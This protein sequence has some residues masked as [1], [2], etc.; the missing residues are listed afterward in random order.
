[1]QSILWGLVLLICLTSGLSVFYSI[2][3]RR[4]SHA[5]YRGLY[6]ARTNI[7]MGFMLVFIALI[8]MFMFEGSTVRVI[9]G[10]VLLVLGAFNLFAGLRNHG[11]FQRHLSAEQK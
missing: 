1:M 8:Q 5:G 2:R 9:V 11:H 7:C 3:S 10:A 4:S 6:A